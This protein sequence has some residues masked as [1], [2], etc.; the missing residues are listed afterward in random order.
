MHGNLSKEQ[1]LS[2]VH[3][4]RETLKPL[5][6]AKEDLVDVRCIALPP[7]KNYLIERD[8]DDTT[9]EN[10]CLLTYYE[11]GP[12]GTDLRTKVLHSVVM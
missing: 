7:G 12:E 4:A 2:I 9:N 5:S 8:L 11:V 1:A 6:I 3:K 10:N